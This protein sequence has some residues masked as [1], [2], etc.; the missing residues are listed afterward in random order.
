MVND[1]L[2]IF[3]PSPLG[4]RAGVRGKKDAVNGQLLIDHC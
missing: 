2:L 1:Q 3:S 4:E